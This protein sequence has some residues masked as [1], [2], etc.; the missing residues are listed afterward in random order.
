MDYK[1]LL[2]Y[3]LSSE[4]WADELTLFFDSYRHY[5]DP[6][7][8]TA[9]WGKTYLCSEVYL[10]HESKM[11]KAGGSYFDLRLSRR[12]FRKYFSAGYSS[13]QRFAILF[14]L[15]W[16]IDKSQIRHIAKRSQRKNCTRWLNYFLCNP[17]SAAADIDSDALIRFRYQ[18]S[19]QAYIF[20]HPPQVNCDRPDEIVPAEEIPKDG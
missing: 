15:W 16:G 3:Y 4:E 10:E 2:E 20:R 1:K 8:G 19:Y 18:G 5:Y 17:R 7:E 13:H 9:K 14:G 11:E 12:Q 6:N